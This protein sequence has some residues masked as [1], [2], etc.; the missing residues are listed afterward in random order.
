MLRPDFSVARQAEPPPPTEPLCDL[1]ARDLAT[2]CDAIAADRYA[3]DPH[4]SDL[5]VDICAQ[6]GASGAALALEEEGAFF[7]RG[8]VGATAPDL[9]LQID[10]RHGLT[11]ECLRSGMPQVC[12][13]AERDPRVGHEAC[14]RLGIRSI[15]VV[16]LLLNACPRGMLAVYSP[17]V[18]AFGSADLHN[19]DILA[20]KITNLLTLS[21][22]APV[23]HQEEMHQ[24]GAHQEQ[25][26][27]NEAIAEFVSMPAVEEPATAT[28][29]STD[30]PD[31][32]SEK[33]LDTPVAA[34]SE[35]PEPVDP[36]PATETPPLPP[37]P[38]GHEQRPWTNRLLALTVVAASVLLGWMISASY[39]FR[40]AREARPAPA[41]EASAAPAPTR[42]VPAQSPPLVSTP[43]ARPPLISASQSARTEHP[44]APD[45]L[46]VY[47]K[48]R[49]VFR[50]HSRPPLD[51]VTSAGSALPPSPASAVPASEFSAGESPSQ[52]K[53]SR[54]SPAKVTGGEVLYR[55]PPVA[56]PEATRLGLRGDVILHV[57]IAKDGTVG[58]IHAVSGDS[59]LVPS[60]I[61]AVRQWRYQPFLQDG[62]PTEVQGKITIHFGVAQQDTQNPSSATPPSTPK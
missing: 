20:R 19:L 22:A 38:G 11:A 34:L 4:V 47:E 41:R 62:T 36:G 55:V 7:C 6:T 59:R 16:P 31:H 32:A 9:G 26:V 61:D 56:P 60:A 57:T 23:V 21:K 30:T 5:L 13:N 14:R 51:T 50:M 3:L 46:I 24:E 40:S 29:A 54:P 12:D 43:A 39:H 17:L 25:E 48:N 28:V 33:N 18:R 27:P 42:P 35:L 2:A 37:T 10:I 58:A 8:S 53:A 1:E 15:V 52:A 49:V 45:D 44:P